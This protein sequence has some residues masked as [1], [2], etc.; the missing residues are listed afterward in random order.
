M[1]FAGGSSGGPMEEAFETNLEAIGG[2]DAA[3]AGDA[4]GGASA[5][6]LFFLGGIAIGMFAHDRT[7]RGLA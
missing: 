2:A 3:G 7:T 4:D 6:L 5:T 1:R